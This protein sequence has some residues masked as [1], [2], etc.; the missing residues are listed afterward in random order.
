MLSI[1]IPVYNGRQFI[2]KCVDALRELACQHEILIIDDGSTDDSLAYMQSA[3]ADYGD[4][5]I[6]SKENGG[7]VSARNYGVAH[8]VGRYICFSD[9]DDRPVAAILD[10]AVQRC[11]AQACDMAY[12][13]TMV[14]RGGRIE[15]CDTVLQDAIVDRDV[16]RDEIIPTYLSKSQNQ[17]VTGMGHLWGALFRR[18]RITENALTFKRFAGYED[19]YLFLLDYLVVAQRICF[20]RDVG[21]YWVRYDVSTSAQQKYIADYWTKMTSMYSYVYE[22]CHQHDITVPVTMDLYVRQSLPLHALQNYASILNPNRRAELREWRRYMQNPEF[23]T[24][25]DQPS[26]RNYEGRDR[27]IYELL[28]RRMYTAAIWYVCMDSAYHALK[29]RRH[30]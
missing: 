22:A 15:P 26:V 25:F 18:D 14:D 10:C 24:A 2:V 20:I 23:S 17:Y 19:D 16:I 1:V 8:A 3:F 29:G 12:W 5:R 9:Q 28:H 6:L 21:Y 30:K 13:S 4:C 27:R 11:E 7:I